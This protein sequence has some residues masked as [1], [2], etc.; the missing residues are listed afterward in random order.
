MQPRSVPFG[1]STS[2]RLSSAGRIQTGGRTADE[3]PAFPPPSAFPRSLFLRVSE[4][5]CLSPGEAVNLM[6]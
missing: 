2:Q 4:L 5:G 3:I 1:L 6:R